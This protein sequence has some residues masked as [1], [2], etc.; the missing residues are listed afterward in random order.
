MTLGNF[1]TFWKSF[2]YFYEMIDLEIQNTSD[3]RFK[4]KFKT[5]Q[6]LL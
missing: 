3:G 2:L 5:I 4:I 1:E 6:R